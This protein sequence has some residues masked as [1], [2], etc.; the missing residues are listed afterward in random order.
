MRRHLAGREPVRRPYRSR[1]GHPQQPRIDQARNTRPGSIA[2]ERRT[3]LMAAKEHISKLSAMVVIGNH[4]GVWIQGIR[5]LAYRIA[6]MTASRPNKLPAIPQITDCITTIR[7]TKPR[8]APR[9]LS[10]AYSSMFSM[11]CA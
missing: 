10:V 1:P 3:E 8:D 11:V 2:S 4:H 6:G 9:A 5:D 7:A